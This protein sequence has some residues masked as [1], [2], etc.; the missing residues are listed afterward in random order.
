VPIIVPLDERKPMMGFMDHKDRKI[1][2]LENGTLYHVSDSNE[3]ADLRGDSVYV[4]ILSNLSDLKNKPI[5]SKNETNEWTSLL[6]QYKIFVSLSYLFILLLA[7]MPLFFNKNLM[8]LLSEFIGVELGE[9][10]KY[11]IGIVA[12]TIAMFPEIWIQNRV[13]G[14]TITFQLEKDVTLQ[15]VGNFRKIYNPDSGLTRHVVYSFSALFK[16]ILSF[17]LFFDF[18]AAI[19]L[20]FASPVLILLIVIHSKLTSPRLSDQEIKVPEVQ[21]TKLYDYICDAWSK[22]NLMGIL[23]LGE[24]ESIEFKSSLWYDYHKAIETEESIKKKRFDPNYKPKNK[25]DMTRMAHNVVKGVCGLLNANKTGK[26]LIGV[27]DNSEVLGLENDFEILGETNNP[28]DDFSTRLDSI[29]R[30]H[31]TPADGSLHDLWNFE[32]FEHEGKVVWLINVN[33]TASGIYCEYQGKQTFYLRRTA[34]TEPVTGVE[35]A[36]ELKRFS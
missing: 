16:G 5:L 31:L 7:A 26:L 25:E 28:K 35:L 32:W 23:R 1:V 24:T 34:K 6:N 33:K 19:V 22:T 21:L 4:P 15:S 30:K 9:W 8:V 17:T 11:L 13:E 12:F 14:E 27:N 10:V 20:L 29:L 2:L 3:N 18:T 36:K